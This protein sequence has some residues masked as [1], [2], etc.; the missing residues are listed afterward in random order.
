MLPAKAFLLNWIPV[1]YW[2]LWHSAMLA[3]AQVFGNVDAAVMRDDV[4]RAGEISVRSITV[5]KM[6]A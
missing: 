4:A 1:Q 2:I 6:E 5:C 3:R